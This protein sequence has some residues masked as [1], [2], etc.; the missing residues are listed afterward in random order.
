[1]NELIQ[2]QFPSWEVRRIAW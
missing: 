2:Q 1:L